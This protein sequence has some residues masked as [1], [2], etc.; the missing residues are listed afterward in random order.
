MR[1]KVHMNRMGPDSSIG[2][3]GEFLQIGG[4]SIL[5]FVCDG[6]LIPVYGS[7]Y[8]LGVPLKVCLGLLESSLGLI[9]AMF[10]ADP[11]ED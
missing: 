8:K 6:A 3:I 4:G 2:S 11:Y 10:R 5:G 9:E 7:F 1:C